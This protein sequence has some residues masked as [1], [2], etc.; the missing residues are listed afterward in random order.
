MTT[1]TMPSYE[2]KIR[3]VAEAFM[4]DDPDEYEGET[5]EE[6]MAQ[7]KPLSPDFINTSYEWF[8]KGGPND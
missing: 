6:V 5:V 1:K 3:A 8:C 2:D 4:K 7:L